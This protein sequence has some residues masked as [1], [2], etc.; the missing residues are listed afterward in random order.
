MRTSDGRRWSPERILMG[1]RAPD[2]A[3]HEDPPKTGSRPADGR[4][5][6][7]TRPIA[8]QPARWPTAAGFPNGCIRDRHR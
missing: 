7:A 8:R 1:P 6:A 2:V 5:I 4:P 3:G